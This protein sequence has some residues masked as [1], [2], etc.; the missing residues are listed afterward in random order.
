MLTKI[1][2]YCE[3]MYK[4]YEVIDSSFEEIGPH[5]YTVNLKSTVADNPDVKIT[6]M[7]DAERRVT[8]VGIEELSVKSTERMF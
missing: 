7:A 2:R 3:L 5:L 6:F 8:P 1:K 4:C